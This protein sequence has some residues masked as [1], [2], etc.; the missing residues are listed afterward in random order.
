MVEVV[1]SQ[2]SRQRDRVRPLRVA[3]GWR[4]CGRWVPPVEHGFRNYGTT[5]RGRALLSL[6][7]PMSGRADKLTLFPP[8]D[9]GVPAAA[10]AVG[11]AMQPRTLASSPARSRSGPGGRC[12][13]RSRPISSPR[14]SSGG[15]PAAEEHAGRDHRRHALPLR[16]VQR[17]HQWRA[18]PQGDQAARERRLRLGHASSSSTSCTGSTKR[19]TPCCPTLRMARSSLSAPPPRTRMLLHQLAAAVARASSASGAGRQALTRILRA[20]LEDA[21]RGLGQLQ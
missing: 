7:A 20:A 2:H 18:G 12:D 9:A 10:R 5:R 17:R 3:C 4:G 14:S 13:R 19:K 15:R 21:E 6:G 16:D 1:L 11:L 8:A